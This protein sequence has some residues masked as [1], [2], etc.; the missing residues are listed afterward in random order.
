MVVKR[1]WPS[2][3]SSKHNDRNRWHP[4]QLPSFSWSPFS[5]NV[6][7]FEVSSKWLIWEKCLQNLQVHIFMMMERRLL[8]LAND[9]WWI[10]EQISFMR[11]ESKGACNSSYSLPNIPR[12]MTYFVEWSYRIFG[13]EWESR[14]THKRHNSNHASKV[15]ESVGGTKHEAGMIWGYGV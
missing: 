1:K 4:P 13:C 7:V 14:G 5:D 15:G 8:T 6:L 2:M 12:C 11:F 3:Y 9:S 10:L